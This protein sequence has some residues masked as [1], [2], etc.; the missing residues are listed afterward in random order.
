MDSAVNENPQEVTLK[1][2]KEYRRLYFTVRH[3][4]VTGC[5]HRLDPGIEPR[6]NCQFCWFAFFKNHGELV[7]TTDSFYQ[8]Y[9]G[10]ALATMRG[11][12]YVKNFLKFMSTLALWQQEVERLKQESNGAQGVGSIS[13][14]SEFTGSNTGTG[15]GQNESDN[16]DGGSAQSPEG[17]R[18]GAERTVQNV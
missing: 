8:E 4:T 5:G 10:E 7:Q 11:R 18:E 12:K 16:L 14:S 9:G 3:P 1:Q 15:D 17:S 13:S 2:I 6:T